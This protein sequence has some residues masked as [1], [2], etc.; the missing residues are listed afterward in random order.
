MKFFRP[1]LAMATIATLYSSTSFASAPT[2]DGNVIK[3]TDAGWHQVQRH[4]TYETMCEGGY[5]CT[6]PPG[7]YTV[8][9]LSTGMR[10][11]EI[12]VL[13][14]SNTGPTRNKPVAPVA[15]TGQVTSYA[16]G[17]DG[18]KQ[19]GKEVSGIRFVN[20][21]NGTFTDKLT[22]LIWMSDRDCIVERTWF[23]AINYANHMSAHSYQCPNLADGS[24]VGDWRLPNIKEL[25]SLV[26]ISD[27]SPVFADG[28]PYTGNN[29]S[30]FPWEQYWSSSSF[31]PATGT[32]AWSLNSQFGQLMPQPKEN[33]HYV[34]IVRN[35]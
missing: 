11:E 32:T 1:L 21:N 29:W 12:S 2:V 20:N 15:R 18:D 22:G 10:Y 25:Y 24:A 19:M 23:A 28:I 5:Q 8:I 30:K 6:V 14:T 17:D 13:G 34:W 16:Y 9:N 7:V 27:S 4:R 35:P 31:E 3:W 33:V 26:D